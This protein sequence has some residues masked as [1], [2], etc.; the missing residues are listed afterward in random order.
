MS[1]LPDLEALQALHHELFGLHQKR[2]ANV[3]ILN[4]LLYERSDDFKKLLDKRPRDANSRTAVNS[5][6]ITIDGQEF[7][8]NSEFI[9]DCLRLAD[10]LDLDELEAARVLLDAQA[11]NDTDALGRPLWQCGIIRFH[12]TRQYLLD[13]MRICIEVIEDDELVIEIRDTIGNIVNEKIYGIPVPGARA[14]AP[15]QKFAPRCMAAMQTIRA[16]LQSV[17][18]RMAGRSVLAASNLMSHDDESFDI[19]RASL[20][21][22]HETLAVMLCS[23][24][25][26]RQVDATDFQDFFRWLKKIDKYDHLLVHLF[27]VL[28]AY[29]TAFGS[30]QGAGDLR[31]AR[32]LN[33][34]VCRQDEN[35]LW[36]IPNLGAAVR[37]WWIAEYSGW[38]M[39][40]TSGYDELRGVNLDEEDDQRTQQFL[41]SLKDGAFDFILSV[42]AD[43]KAQDW[44]DPSRLGMR[45]WLQRKSPPLASDPFPFA[46]F[47]QQNL[48]VH[49]EVMIDAAISNLPDILRQLRTDEDEQR[50]LSQ[51]HEQDLDLERFLIIISYAYEGRPE[52]GAA[53]WESKDSNLSG[54]LAWASRRA[55]TPL[56]SAFCEMLLCVSED[57]H[58]ATAAHA[59]LLDD[60]A[61]SSGKMKRTQ[62]LTWNQI[63]KELD[64]FTTKLRERPSPAQAHIHRPGKPNT[65]QAEAEPESSMM[66]EC[67]LRL[68]AKLCTESE[69]ARQKLLMDDELHL[70]DTLFKLASGVIPPRLRACTFYVLK[71]LLTR[72]NQMEASVMWKWLDSWLT[73]GFAMQPSPR[74]ALLA[75]AQNP[76][77]L[78]EAILDEI[79]DGF[80]E[81]NAFI[82]FLISLMTPVE[83]NEELNDSLPFPEDLGIQVRIPGVE[84]YVDYV[85]GHVFSY[86]SKDIQDTNQLRMIRLSCMEFAMLCLTIFNE[87]LI[88]LGNEAAHIAIDKAISTTDL[89]TYVRLHPFARVMEW[90]FNDKFIIALMGTI[91]QDSAALGSASPDSPLVLS[92]LRAIEVVLKVFELQETYFNLVRPVIN[93]QA[94]SR[95]APVANSSYSCF[96]DGIMNHLTLVVDLGR[97]C[98]L[99]HPELTMACLKLLENIS[100]SSKMI[101][102]WN[103][104]AGQHGHRNKAIVQLEKNGESETI[105]A[106]LAAEIAHEFDPALAV[107][108]PKDV[109]NYTIKL[110]ILDF[111]YQCLKAAPDQPTIAHLL[112]G[113]RCGLNALTVERRGAFDLQKSLF[114][115]LLNL[116][117]QFPVYDEPQGMRGPVIALKWRILRIFQ[118]LWTSSLSNALVM[119]E[120]RTVAF[121]F[122][123]L[124]QEMEIVPQLAWDGID[125]S[126]P[127]F[128]ITPAS[129][130][131]IDFLGARAILFEYGSKELCSVS[132]NRIPTIKRQIFDALNGQISTDDGMPARIPTIFDFF[133]FLGADDQWDIPVPQFQHYKD[134]DLSACA[135]DDPDSGL[136]YNVRK[137]QEVLL[138]KRSEQRAENII[139]PIDDLADIE[140]EEALLKE[141]LVFSNRQKQFKA[142]RLRVLRSWA[143]LILVMLESNDLKGTPKMNLLLQTLQA[144]LPSFE[145]LSSLDP[146]ESYEL[147]RVAKMLL[148]KLEFPDPN[149]VAPG[150]DQVSAT[151]GN[152]ISDK[153][154]QLFQICLSSIGKWAASAELRAL[155]YSICYRYLTAV[156]DKNIQGQGLVTG[157]PKTLKAIQAHGERLLGVICDDA[158][159]SDTGCQT[160]AMILLSALVHLGRADDDAHVVEVLNRLNFIGV[161]VDSLKTVLADWLAV[162]N[163]SN[164]AAEQYTNAKLALLLQLCQSRI[165]AK[166]VLQ[167]NLFRALELSGVFA[168]DPE[169]Q[170]DAS[171]TRALEKHY[172]L[173]VSLSRIISAAVL[174]R[175]SHNII[176]GRRFL[177]QHRMLVVHT[178]KR[179]A[180]IGT[181]GNGHSAARPGLPSGSLRAPPPSP[182]NAKAQAALE[183]RIEELAEAFM[184]LITATEFLEFEVDQVPTERHRVAPTVFH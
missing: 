162:I 133:D 15:A 88:I 154:F 69:V 76:N 119:A 51:N 49:L 183:E 84:V 137:V 172:A 75:A 24:I 29:V 114:H 28:G 113:F 110:S 22:Q 34:M 26:K 56:V 21:S 139:I 173:L 50:Q 30:T 77:S 94:G 124:T 91:Q 2:K 131:F 14:L 155:Y 96:E 62:S 171:N 67:Y 143:N 150:L 103:P 41:A 78:T 156:V 178:L 118:V 134:I 105:A 52:A 47:F 153:L 71:A 181:V 146:T 92:I 72:K 38:Y 138:L 159:G 64:F 90:M 121:V 164:V 4:T 44:Q 43:C 10:E 135:E 85:L 48:M 177:G 5:G 39:E 167:A 66:L 68:I 74:T 107:V 115:A 130:S 57:E 141:Y 161:I 104:D 82:Q 160:A 9:S 123:M 12:R 117:I 61:Q 3:Q 54:F 165:G 93:K 17:Q 19:M 59:F 132:Q 18:E 86:K 46:P 53:F 145:G 120:L 170:I 122:H 125:A 20:L 8:I 158:Y 112:L 81:P 40:D 89:A 163:D 25:E 184:V 45:K 136:Q 144:I 176:Q 63:F 106:S 152:L 142:S 6:K 148:F 127:E 13:C 166:Y 97:Y 65:D 98:G 95:R 31:L 149:N 35:D 151:V 174:T 1:G 99:C 32:Q 140:R 100:T 27:P 42:A 108:D 179:S 169:L 147:A 126:D 73:G 109:P 116:L 111:L 11:E 70:V 60:G 7:N 128:P 182:G 102:A 157:R 23:A 87:D 16:T 129:A 33:D 80:E 79:S 58:C 168:A 101:S 55:S 180:G 37:A 83:G 36:A 175:G